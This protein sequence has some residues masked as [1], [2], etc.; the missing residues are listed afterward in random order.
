MIRGNRA[1]RERER[2]SERKRIEDSYQRRQ[3]RERC[4]RIGNQGE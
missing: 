1:G 2:M 4:R 3:K